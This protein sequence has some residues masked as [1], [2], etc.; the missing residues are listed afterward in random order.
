MP[1]KFGGATRSAHG[2]DLDSASERLRQSLRA[3]GAQSTP[4]TIGSLPSTAQPRDTTT[5]TAGKPKQLVFKGSRNFRMRLVC[6]TL[7]GREVRIQDIRVD[8]KSPGLRGSH[9]CASSAHFPCSDFEAS[10]L[11]ILEKMSN[12]AVIQINA[13]GTTLR[14]VPGLLVGGGVSHDCAPARCVF[15]LCAC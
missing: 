11:R 10:F 13:T 4:T 1:P 12:G 8:D 6:A 2:K 15:L 3:G 14:Y 7:A 5:V 9:A